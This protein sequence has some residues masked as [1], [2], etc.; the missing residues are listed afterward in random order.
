MLNVK[1]RAKKGLLDAKIGCIG[2]VSDYNGYT[3]ASDGQASDTGEYTM[4]LLLNKP[5]YYLNKPN[6]SA[7]MRSVTLRKSSGLSANSKVSP[8]M[9]M[10]RPL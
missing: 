4:F 3:F 9:M 2:Q 7:S 5:N 1:Y 6:S 10:S 8:S